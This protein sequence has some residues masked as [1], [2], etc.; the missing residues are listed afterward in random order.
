MRQAGKAMHSVHFD[1]LSVSVRRLD[2]VCGN[3]MR[4]TSQLFNGLLLTGMYY[5]SGRQ[6]NVHGDVES[7]GVSG[8][9]IESLLMLI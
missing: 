9:D 1:E 7:D 2:G 5:K 6:R 4:L 3:F 8:V